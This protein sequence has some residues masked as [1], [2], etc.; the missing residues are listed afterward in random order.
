MVTKWHLVTKSAD[1]LG[2]SA[3]QMGNCGPN[4]V[5]KWKN[6]LTNWKN[7]LTKWKNL[8]SKWHLVSKCPFADQMGNVDQMGKPS[9]DQMEKSAD[10]LEKSA[11]QMEKSAEQMAFGQQMPFG[12]QLA[13][14]SADVSC[15]PN[16]SGPGHYMNITIL[17]NTTSAQD[18]QPH[19][20]HIGRRHVKKP[21]AL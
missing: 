7:L 5:T 9:A 17:T 13:T 3:E 15:R 18:T 21:S 10:Q 19:E 16:E 1:Q 2:K 6:L 14:C 8:L 11:D 20:N 12:A 4:L